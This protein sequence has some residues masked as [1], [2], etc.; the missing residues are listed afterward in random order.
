MIMEEKKV[1]SLLKLRP[2]CKLHDINNNIMTHYNQI[3]IK[4]L[5]LKPIV[6][7]G[8]VADHIKNIMFSFVINKSWRLLFLVL[9]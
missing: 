3:K 9:G 4:C 7:S 5:H 8:Y 1:H 6:M 2:M